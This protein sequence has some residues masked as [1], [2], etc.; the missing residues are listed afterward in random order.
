MLQIVLP[1]LAAY[2]PWCGVRGL[3]GK[4]DPGQ[5]D[6]QT[7]KPVAV[8]CIVIAIGIALFALIGLPMI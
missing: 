4:P 8:A 2:V 7:S 3:V 6:T 1:A 5:S